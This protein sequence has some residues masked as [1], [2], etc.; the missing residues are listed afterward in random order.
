MSGRGRRPPWSCH[1]FT[2]AAEIA[3]AGEQDAA[4]S[5]DNGV[6]Q[7]AH[8]V[9]LLLASGDTGRRHLLSYRVQARV[10]AFSDA[11]VVFVEGHA[12]MD[13]TP[14]DVTPEAHVAGPA[15][16]DTESGEHAVEAS[17]ER[18]EATAALRVE[19]EPE[20]TMSAA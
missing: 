12:P 19:P 10:A 20:D 7:A 16:E 9:R 3:A 5:I 11:E 14:E 8:Q 4:T 13:V 15:A 17:D 6:A 1:G 18:P 2:L